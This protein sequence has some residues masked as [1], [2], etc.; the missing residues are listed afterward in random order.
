[1]KYDKGKG[2]GKAKLVG[3]HLKPKHIT[4]LNELEEAMPEGL[5]R[6]DLIRYMVLPYIEALTLAK[7]G[8]E[9]RGALELGKGLLLLRGLLKKAEQEANQGD[10][11]E[12]LQDIPNSVLAVPQS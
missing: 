6:S 5:C 8:K 11:Y 1:M 4:V 10:F 3:F 9:W 7:E 2:S 12:E